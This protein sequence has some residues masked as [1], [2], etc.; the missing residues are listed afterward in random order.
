MAVDNKSVVVVLSIF[1][2]VL[3]RREKSA[4][5]SLSY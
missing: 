4:R 2:S 5:G 3:V 1:I